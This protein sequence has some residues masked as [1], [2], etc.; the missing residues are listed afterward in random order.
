MAGR[1][2]LRTKQFLKEHLNV[3]RRRQLK[4]IGARVRRPLRQARR[5]S[6]R[7]LNVDELTTCLREAGIDDG[8]AIVVHSS[9]SAVGNVDGGAETVIESLVRAVGGDGTVLMPTF[10]DAETVL[11]RQAGGEQV[12]LRREPSVTGKV[13]EVFRMRSGSLRSSHPFSSVAALGG[14][15]AFVTEAHQTDP[16]IAHGASP[17]ARLRELDGTIVGIGVG[18]GP[19]SFYHVLE[20]TWD[21]F[22]IKVYLPPVEISYVD[23]DGCS[24][25]RPVCRYNADVVRTR[26]DQPG[27]FFLRDWFTRHLEQRGVLRTFRYGE[28]SAWT[29]DANSLYDE[30]QHLARRGITIYSSKDDLLHTSL[31]LAPNR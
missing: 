25:S 1:Y 12:D 19:V 21:A 20:D 5:I 2:F 4:A 23:R 26:I 9:L 15:A 18:L 10:S 13:T 24:I 11:N 14:K 30:L 7:D 6:R 8:H 22:P 17:L 3:K 16:R 31:E 28:A 29:M 27:S